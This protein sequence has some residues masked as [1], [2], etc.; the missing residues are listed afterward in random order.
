MPNYA[1]VLFYLLFIV[2]AVL[3]NC[4]VPEFGGK[5]NAHIDDALFFVAE[6]LR[7]ACRRGDVLVCR[8]S[9]GEIGQL[10]FLEVVIR[11]L[12]RAV[13]VTSYRLLIA[14]YGF[15][16]IVAGGNVAGYGIGVGKVAETQ[17][18]DGVEIDCIGIKDPFFL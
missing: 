9:S 8:I 7:P 15:Q 12:I 14:G 2:G 5:R 3:D 1:A 17:V 4:V 16:L 11:R 18:L 13:D 6:Y 10:E